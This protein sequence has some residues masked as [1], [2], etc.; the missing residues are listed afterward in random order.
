MLKKIAIKL[1]IFYQKK[2]P[3]HIRDNC[4]FEPTCSNYAI[5]AF[6]YYGF[7]KGLKLTI[8]RLLRCKPPNGGVDN[9][10]K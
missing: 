5:E 3:K 4:L 10:P 7:I 9:L 6:E 8:S 2:A 1:I